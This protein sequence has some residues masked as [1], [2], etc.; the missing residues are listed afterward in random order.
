LRKPAVELIYR[1]HRARLAAKPAT[2]ACRRIYISRVVFKRN[3]KIALFS[4]QVIDFRIGD[5]L[6]ICMAADLDQL[7]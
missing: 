7:G 1:G 3:L 6:Y 5:H 2:R 4:F